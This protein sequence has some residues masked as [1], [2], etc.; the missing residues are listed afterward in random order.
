MKFNVLIFAATSILMWLSPVMAQPTAIK[1]QGNIQFISDA[2]MERIEGTAPATGEFN[3]DKQS[4]ASISGKASVSVAGMKTGND[5]RDE[6]LRSDSWLD[7]KQFPEITFTIK[8]ASPNGDLKKN[9]DVSAGTVTLNGDLSLHGV[10]KSIST[11]ADVKWK[12][13]KY[14]ITSKF[15]VKLAD[16]KVEGASGIVGSK[17]GKTIDISVSLRG[18]GN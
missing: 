9:G 6:H 8:S 16:F 12:G 10:T 3:I 18:K 13:D 2:P 4:L 15:Q 5:K 7:A 14:K 11:K 1:F 17:V